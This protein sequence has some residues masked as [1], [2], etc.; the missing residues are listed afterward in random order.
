MSLSHGVALHATGK[1]VPSLVG[2]LQKTVSPE[3]SEI[4]S[5]S[6][7]MVVS[8]LKKKATSEQVEKTLTEL[9][10]CVLNEIKKNDVS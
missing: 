3:C 7:L 6:Q 4:L 1:F 10:E 8:A 2:Q 9:K 5:T